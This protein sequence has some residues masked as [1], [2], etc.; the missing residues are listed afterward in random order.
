MIKNLQTSVVA[1]LFFL[2]LAPSAAQ[3]QVPRWDNY[4]M[5]VTGIYNNRVY[6]FALDS[7]GEIRLLSRGFIHL[8][9]TNNHFS[10]I[11]RDL[12]MDYIETGKYDTTWLVLKRTAPESDGNGGTKYYFMQGYKNGQFVKYYKSDFGSFFNDI[13]S[14]NDDIT[15]FYID[16]D[17]NK[18]FGFRNGEIGKID[19]QNNYTHFTNSVTTGEVIDIRV[20][21]VDGVLYA[22]MD[23]SV[24]KYEDDKWT[25]IT[26]GWGLGTGVLSI[27]PK[28]DGSILMATFTGLYKLDNNVV[29]NYNTS[30][31][32]IP[33]N[34]IVD[35]QQKG[36][37]VLMTCL[38]A[39]G[40]DYVIDEDF[41]LLYQGKTTASASSYSR[42][43]LLIENESPL[44]FWV[45]TFA[46]GLAKYQNGTTYFYNNLTIGLPITTQARYVEK[47]TFVG[48]N[49]YVCARKGLT[50]K[51][52]SLFQGLSPVYSTPP[53]PLPLETYLD[54]AYDSGNFV[55]LAT[56][57]GLAQLNVATNEVA[58]TYTTPNSSIFYKVFPLKKDS[59]LAVS[60]GEFMVMAG[61]GSTTVIDIPA[62]IAKGNAWNALVPEINGTSVAGF[63]LATNSG[64]YYYDWNSFTEYNSYYSTVK[65]LTQGPNG[66]LWLGFNTIDFIQTFDKTS[67]WNVINLP[68]ITPASLASEEITDLKFDARDTLWL[69]ASYEGNYGNEQSKLLSYGNGSFTIIGGPSTTVSNSLTISPTGEK[70]ISSDDGLYIYVDDSYNGLDPCANVNCPEGTV[71][72]N[73]ICEPI[74]DPC[75]GISCGSN[76]ICYAG[77]CFDVC[78]G[79][80]EDCVNLGSNKIVPDGASVTLDAGT[81]FDTF[82]WSTGATS[83]SITVS[84]S[85][86]YW[87]TAINTNAGILSRD[88]VAVLIKSGA[89]GSC[90]SGFVNSDGYCVPENDLCAGVTCGPNKTCYFGSCF[91][92]LVDCAPGETMVNDVCFDNIGCA[93]I[94]CPEGTTCYAGQCFDVCD[95]SIEDCVNLGSNKIVPDGASVTLDAGTAFDTFEWSTGATSQSIT[96]STSGA[97][98]VT[99]I[100]TNAGILSRDTVAVLIK[101]GAD[102]SCPSGFVNSDGYCVP[103]NDLC[104]GVTCGPNK[105][106][107]FGSCFDTLVDCAPG[108]TMVNDVCFDNIGCAN[109]SCPEGYLCANAECYEQNIIDNGP[110]NVS[111]SLFGK[112]TGSS[113]TENVA[114]ENANIYFMNESKTEINGSAV[115]DENGEYIIE[116]L[117]AGT[118]SVFVDYPPYKVKDDGII[119][120]KSSAISTTID[121]ILSG[122]EYEVVLDYI[123]GLAAQLEMSNTF[124]I[125]PNPTQGKITLSSNKNMGK[126]TLRITD[127]DGKVLVEK[128]MVLHKNDNK[129]LTDFSN[130]STGLKLITIFKKGE[131]IYKKSILY[132]SK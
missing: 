83:Q 10:G 79:S 54:V 17:G 103:E 71:C 100:N 1:L 70:L 87:V 66:N 97:Y 74:A 45:G 127:I 47:T 67:S 130:E 124:S 95:G 63:W 117:P 77:Q 22:S 21:P 33:T 46:D 126:V 26:E 58:N 72:N 42:P 118:Y 119:I 39:D 69:L 90:P 76:K 88:T 49:T 28:T 78:D 14:Y 101:S 105:T 110:I 44:K 36:N 56:Y 128:T 61:D 7:Q 31:S 94:S 121:L 99:A 24:Y 16:P 106:C 41:N 30:N 35:I 6:D 34:R 12:S 51:K 5:N 38:A 20:S 57:G 11:D 80:I 85:G 98:W 82:E 86:A 53:V 9:Q 65:S 23:N 122:E 111:G 96:V 84:T 131:L 3:S 81:A 48:D 27:L 19:L 2:V 13:N 112:L 104:A 108:E 25:N 93:N 115:T 123:T 62:G 107:Y 73:G 32:T 109:I 68:E 129:L 4:N 59:V 29:T 91:D 75:D 64:F 114:I 8:D 18:W 92:T 89:D 113:N 43:K 102:G 132:H 40:T 60:Y 37:L 15:V 116:H 125:Y 120:L 55:Y 52:D 50:I